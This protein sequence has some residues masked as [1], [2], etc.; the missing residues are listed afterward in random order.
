[1]TVAFTIES[2]ETD[3]PVTKP[4]RTGVSHDP[5]VVALYN[6][7]LKPR[8]IPTP[9]G[10]TVGTDTKDEAD[11]LIAGLRAVAGADKGENGQPLAS[12]RRKVTP[13]DENNPEGPQSIVLWLSPFIARPR[14]A[15]DEATVQ[16]AIDA[17]ADVVAEA[18]AETPVFQEPAVEDEGKRKGRWGH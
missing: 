12:V 2:A 4:G 6:E 15:K 13:K 1:M 7:T 14:K 8:G 17:G 10:I 18:P 3:V 9:K 5:K 16:D 11:T